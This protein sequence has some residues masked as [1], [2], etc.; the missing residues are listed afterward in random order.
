MGESWV[1]S[2]F[3]ESPTSKKNLA[4]ARWRRA[5]TIFPKISTRRFPRREKRNLRTEP[6]KRRL[7]EVRP[8][9]PRLKSFK[10]PV[11]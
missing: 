11:K 1:A 4:P 5:Q 8:N 2:V 10:R 9:P 7:F 6:S 3:D